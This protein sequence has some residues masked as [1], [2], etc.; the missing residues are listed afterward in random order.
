MQEEPAHETEKGKRKGGWHRWRAEEARRKLAEQAS[1][2]LSL[3]EFARREGLSA[4]RLFR[5]RKRLESG[6][7]LLSEG[8][9]IGQDGEPKMRFLP[10]V[11]VGSRE[12]GAPAVSVR[13]GKGLVLEVADPRAVPA[14]WIAEVVKA[15]EKK[16]L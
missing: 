16:A 9:G 5:W 12:Q 15:L 13:L 2:G 4:A 6:A 3:V 7:D 11:A 14:S 1:S 8:S 10:M